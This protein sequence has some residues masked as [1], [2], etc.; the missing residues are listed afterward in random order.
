MNEEIDG[1]IGA[2]LFILFVV[3]EILHLEY[4]NLLKLLMQLFIS[5]QHSEATLYLIKARN[6]FLS[7]LIALFASSGQVFIEFEAN[8][9]VLPV[10]LFFLGIEQDADKWL[11]RVLHLLESWIHDTEYLFELLLL[12]VLSLFSRFTYDSLLNIYL[13]IFYCFLF[14]LHISICKV[15]YCGSS[16]RAATGVSFNYIFLKGFI[17]FFVDEA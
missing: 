3:N 7:N 8:E 16:F 15:I 12:Y 17:V 1:W 9:I 10:K 4:V 2:I 14:F 13:L 6:T 5:I 11:V